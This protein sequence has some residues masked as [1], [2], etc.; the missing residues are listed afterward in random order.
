MVDLYGGQTV[1]TFDPRVL[2]VVDQDPSRPGAQIKPG[3][4]PTPDSVLRNAASNTSGRLEY[5]FTL[6]GE[7]PGVSGAGTVA[8][9]VLRGAG[10]GRSLLAITETV[11]S[12]PQ[13]LAIPLKTEN[14]LLTVLDA[15]VASVA[16]QVELERRPT[17]AGA[18]VCAGGSCTSSDAAGRFRL[19]NVP[20]G[21]PVEVTHPSYLRTE[22][23][24]PAN[25][26]GTVTWPKVKLLAGDLDKDDAVDIVDAVMIGQRFNL[27][28]TPGGANPRWLEATD[29][30]DDDTVNI[31]DMT[32]VQFNFLKTAPTD[33]PS[34]LAARGAAAVQA[35]RVSLQPAEER[36]EG[37]GVDI[38]LE[39]RVDEV[40]RLYGFR[41]RLRFDP[42]MLEVKDMSPADPGVQVAVGEFLDPINSIILLNQADNATGTLDLSLTQTAPAT[43]ANGSGVL[44]TITF[45]GRAGGSSQVTL[46]E[47]ILVDDGEPVPATIPA[48]NAGA[49][50]TIED[51]P[52]ALYLPRLFHPR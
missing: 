45:R 48:Q 16:G 15:P 18:R 42:A 38:P 28:F 34:Q 39:L 29:I 7:K 46:P 20:V 27:R 51:Q 19:D 3:D 32:G 24:L 13:S 23:T 49:T 12:D 9:I 26:S 31:L 35:A 6:T 52:R 2:Q 30:T 25:A 33:W 44:A 17:S 41:V 40:A 50:V 11:L 37:L 8:H 5:Y 4:F 43:A 36:V 22:R 10:P 47:V 14:A 21:R 1:V